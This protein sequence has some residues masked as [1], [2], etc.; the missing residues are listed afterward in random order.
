MLKLLSSPNNYIPLSLKYV[1]LIFGY[2]SFTIVERLSVLHRYLNF[3]ALN[4][5]IVQIRM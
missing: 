2:I 4:S 1:Y 3:I 5:Q